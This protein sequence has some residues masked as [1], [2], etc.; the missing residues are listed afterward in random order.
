MKIKQLNIKELE[1]MHYEVEILYKYLQVT[2]LRNPKY[3]A[4]VAHIRTIGDLLIEEE[5]IDVIR[6]VD[7]IEEEKKT[8]FFGPDHWDADGINHNAGLKDNGD[9]TYACI[10]PE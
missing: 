10:R 7:A 3:D 6:K 1:K 2:P 5:I 8:E 9:G 4:A